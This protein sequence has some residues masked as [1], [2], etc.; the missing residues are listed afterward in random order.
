MNALFN[1][2]K[3][4]IL[5]SVISFVISIFSTGEI[6]YNSMVSGYSILTLGV[7]IIIL[8]L[9]SKVSQT[10]E[11]SWLLVLKN[12]G[13]FLSML[14]IIAFVLYLIIYYKKPILNN[15]VSESYHTFSNITTILLLIQIYI[16]YTNIV[17]DEF[18]S[19]DKNKFK[20]SNTTTGVL[21]LLS[22]LT[23]MSSLILFVIL[24]YFRA[25]GFQVLG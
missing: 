23:S 13:P 4:L 1:T 11:N 22:L 6:S 15:Q 3:A 20:L 19:G 12:F 18:S 2:Y 7:M 21:I 14:S 25:D 5:G 17:S 10:G 24:K 8:I 16:V 9:Y